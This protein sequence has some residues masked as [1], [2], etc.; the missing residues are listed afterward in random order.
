MAASLQRVAAMTS[1]SFCRCARQLTQGP[2][3][4]FELRMVKLM[5]AGLAAV[6]VLCVVMGAGGAFLPAQSGAA[7]PSVSFSR[8]TGLQPLVNGVE[9]RD[10]GLV[11]RIS[12]LRDDVLRIRMGRDGKLPEDAS[13]AVLPEARAAAVSV[14]QDATNALVGFHTKT[15]RVE[16]A[17]ATGLLTIRDAAG[18]VVQQE[19]RPIAFDGA[20]VLVSKAMPSDEHYFG[21][22]DKTGAFDRRGGA[23][24]LWNTDAYAWQESTDPLYKSIPFYLSYRAGMAMGVLLDNTWPSTFDFGKTVEGQM[25]YSA[26]GG[27]VDEYIL[28]GPSAKQ[29]LGSYA[30]LTGPTPLPPLWALGYQQSR[31]S[32]MTQARVLEVA[33]RLRAD[34]IPVDAIYLDIDYQLKNRPFTIDTAAFPDI[35]GM[36]ETLHREKLHVVAITDLHIADQPGQNYAPFESG[37]AGDHFVKNADGSLYVGKVWPGPSVFPDFTRAATRAWWG[38]LYKDLTRMGVDGF[39]N[40]MNEPSV[41]TPHLTIPDEALH[42]IDEPGFAKRTATHREI[43]NVYG[44]ENVRATFDGQ[45]ALKPDARP[46]V[47]TRASYAGGQRY[48]ATWTGD[49]SATW[50]HLRL[51]TTM[52]K[53]LGLSGFSLAGAD[54]GGYA[55]TPSPELLT[56]WLEIAAFQPIDRD[57]AEK[58][59]GDH[60]PWANGPEQEQIRRRFIEERY[61]LLPYLYTV[62]EDNTRTGLPLLRPLFLEYPGAAPDGHPLDIDLDASGEFMVGPDLLVAAPPFP[63]K[64]DAYDAK[65]PSPGWYD[66]WT[67]GKVGEGLAQ[68]AAGG[69]QPEAGAGALVSAVKI[70]P[71]LAS[72]P[73]FARPGAMIPIAPLVQST[74][75]EPRG[76]LTLRVFPGEHCAGSLYQDD[77]TSYAYKQGRYL[78]MS[79]TCEVSTQT[80]ELRIRL[81]KHEGSYPAWWQEVALEVN[82]VAARPESVTVNG[83]ASAVRYQNRQLLIEVRDAGNG[84]DI[85]V[86]QRER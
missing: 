71:E 10:G 52:L 25:Q 9:L 29:V 86:P 66:Y 37:A 17:R 54:V 82:G 48:A 84:V 3:V 53:N 65:L 24:R 56:K 4:E 46:F 49:N 2:E 55:G 28:Y 73:V 57:H 15:L 32:Y 64:M 70:H 74:M 11:M 76:P 6:Q 68:S 34:K 31:Y 18:K 60:E 72:L 39:W 5:R 80:G 61:K 23:F 1:V 51:T 36:V 30:W 85:V 81:S 40:D 33:Q 20:S 21:L 8:V 16:V 47:L 63:D 35:A 62:M 27:A 43:H 69:L 67:G 45:L 7:A 12:A 83:V 44:Q 22:G 19:T 77:G 38:S 41:F 58:G 42:R 78:R 59:T 79:F 26:E 75:E 50:N 13:W 14:V